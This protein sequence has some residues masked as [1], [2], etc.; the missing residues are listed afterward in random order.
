MPIS[1]AGVDFPAL[2]AWNTPEGPAPPLRSRP[3]PPCG[4]EGG[5]GNCTRTELEQSIWSWSKA[6]G[7]MSWEDL[8]RCLQRPRMDEAGAGHG[9]QG[10][11]WTVGDMP[12]RHCRGR[13]WLC[14]WDQGPAPKS[15]DRVGSEEG[16]AEGYSG[17]GCGLRVRLYPGESTE[18]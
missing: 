8:V 7:P 11:G 14:R 6:T 2:P 9:F 10:E 16:D 12:G 15:T 17:P 3:Q 5:D 4:K 13:C 18:P 1:M